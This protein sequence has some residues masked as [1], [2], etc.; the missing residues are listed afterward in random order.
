M[1]EKY[2]QI[3]RIVITTAIFLLSFVAAA[4]AQSPSKILKQAEKALGGTSSLK[5]VRSSVKVGSIKR[6]SD[7]AAGKYL[8]Q[9]TQPNLLNIVIEID[10]FETEIGYNGR[11]GWSRNSR[12]GLQTLTGKA[13]IDLQAKASFRNNLWLN[14]KTDKAKI[15]SGGQSNIDGKPINIVTLTTQKGVVIKIYFDTVS[16]LPV[17]DEIPGGDMITAL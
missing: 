12:D 1:N 13:S 5:A 11:S 7:G 14:Y 8:F 3:L 17:R 2:I 10:G 6:L 4:F 15:I 16:G 9:T